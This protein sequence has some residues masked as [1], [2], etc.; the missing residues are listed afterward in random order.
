MKKKR[1]ILN[2]PKDGPIATHLQVRRITNRSNPPLP[3][4]FSSILPKHS[5]EGAPKKKKEKK[6]GVSFLARTFT[7][8]GATNSSA[9]VD[10]RDGSWR[11]DRWTKLLPFSGTQPRSGSRSGAETWTSLRPTPPPPCEPSGFSKSRAR[12]RATTSEGRR[13]LAGNRRPPR[14]IS[15]LWCH[16]LD[17]TGETRAGRRRE[18]HVGARRRDAY[19]DARSV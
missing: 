5:R 4:P 1:K 14:R 2:S 3:R 8:R 15:S 9:E 16:V 12:E 19:T 11:R 17:S 6:S 10:D 18:K 13:R 7:S